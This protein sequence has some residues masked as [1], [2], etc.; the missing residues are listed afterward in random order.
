MQGYAIAI[1][2][3]LVSGYSEDNMKR[4]R[5]TQLTGNFLAG[6]TIASCSKTSEILTQTADPQ[7]KSLRIWWEEGFYPEEIDALKQIIAKWK[8]T[9]DI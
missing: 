1:R 5:F 9:V 3:H 2:K 8:E 6:V 4:R 7:D